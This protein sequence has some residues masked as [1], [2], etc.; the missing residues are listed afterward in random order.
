M[1]FFDW[2]REEYDV[3]LTIAGFNKKHSSYLNGKLDNFNIPYIEYQVCV[4]DNSI[5]SI[6][7]VV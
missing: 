3:Q 5:C 4:Y 7:G 2:L 6:K 1:L